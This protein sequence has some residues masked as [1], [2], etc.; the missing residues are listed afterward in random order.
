MGIQSEW[1]LCCVRRYIHYYMYVVYLHVNV[2]MW[3]C[4]H[5]YVLM[6]TFHVVI[7]VYML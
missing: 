2:L 5:V 3:I 1:S 6:C 4:I 7:T